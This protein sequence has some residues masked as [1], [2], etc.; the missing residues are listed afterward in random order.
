MVWLLVWDDDGGRLYPDYWV[1]D[2][3]YGTGL[4]VLVS[5]DVS[6]FLWATGLA[7]RH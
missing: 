7:T 5:D 1:A 2:P 4:R 3:S 6:Y